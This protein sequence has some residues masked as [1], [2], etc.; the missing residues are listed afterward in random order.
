MFGN[1][2]DSAFFL[3]LMWQAW[4]QE[5]AEGK[6]RKEE[7]REREEWQKQF[8]KQRRET[9]AKQVLRLGF[10]FDSASKGSL[11]RYAWSAW[12]D[13]LRDS[14][15]S[16]TL[17]VRQRLFEEQRRNSLQENMDMAAHARAATKRHQD[18][19]AK[20]GILFVWAQKDSRLLTRTAWS[21]WHQFVVDRQD[22]KRKLAVRMTM[23]GK[24]PTATQRAVILVWR[25]ILLDE[26]AASR[27]LAETGLKGSAMN[28]LRDDADVSRPLQPGKALGG[29]QA[30]QRRCLMRC[31]SFFYRTQEEKVQVELKRTASGD[32]SPRLQKASSA[33]SMVT[34]KD[35]DPYLFQGGRGAK[36]EG[37]PPSPT[38]DEATEVKFVDTDGEDVSLRRKAN[39]K[40]DYY[41]N[42]AP[43]L[44]DLTAVRLRGGALDLVGKRADGR[45]AN[46]VTE[47]QNDAEHVVARRVVALYNGADLKASARKPPAATRCRCVEDTMVWVM[48]LCS[49]AENVYTTLYFDDGRFH[50][51]FIA[52]VFCFE[53]ILDACVKQLL[54]CTKCDW[55]N[56][57]YDLL[58]QGGKCFLYIYFCSFAEMA[59][60]VLAALMGGQVL[61]IIALKVKQKCMDSAEEIYE[62][63][64]ERELAVAAQ[65]MRAVWCVSSNSFTL[66]SSLFALAYLLYQD[67]EAPYRQ[68]SFEIVLACYFWVCDIGLQYQFKA[69]LDAVGPA[70]KAS[71]RA[72]LQCRSI[73]VMLAQV[74]Q[75]GFAV[76]VAVLAWMYWFSTDIEETF[77]KVYTIATMVL[78]C[79]EGIVF[80]SVA[81]S[82]LCKCVMT[83]RVSPALASAASHDEE[84]RLDP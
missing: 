64:R 8:D 32:M 20:R 29:K 34:H 49:L 45:T 66:F 26:K 51:I 79:I 5:V 19:E 73:T 50:I 27:R 42:G 18:V 16:L 71:I 54:N 6:R 76:Y 14:Q 37:L 58:S 46:W 48:N 47:P 69:L 31:I 83:K 62:R 41:A 56:F 75:L 72:M 82:M 44:T 68:K 81:V 28:A 63:E 23:Q 84:G 33:K 10:K 59:V 15:R 65:C 36:L 39:G 43:K 9:N 22:V 17:D 7:Q 11:L 70:G 3:K 38:G 61:T 21:A 74:A 55:H 57:L 4:V 80:T 53:P 13:A 30:R 24:D 78:S 2:S 1:S 67:E 52:M 77:D 40:L 60:Y 12:M 35:S 25:R